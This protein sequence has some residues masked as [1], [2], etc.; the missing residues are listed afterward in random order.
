MNSLKGKWILIDGGDSYKVGQVAEVN[1]D[2]V[3]IRL[4]V[5]SGCPIETFYNV[6]HISELSC[7]CREC[8]NS[9]FFD[10]EEQLQRWIT[11][12]NKTDDNVISIRSSPPTPKKK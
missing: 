11:W 5:N 8:V 12:V 4:R 3:L 9:Y 7:E 1:G 6:Y 2:Y 10:N